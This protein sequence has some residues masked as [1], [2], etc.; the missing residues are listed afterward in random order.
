[1]RRAR[2]LVCTGW[3]AGLG[4]VLAPA[5]APAQLEGACA[6]DVE[7]LC[8]DVP[9][10]PKLRKCIKDKQPEF[11]AECKAE[12]EEREQRR[13]AFLDSCS[14]DIRTYCAN[15]ERGRGRLRRCL[16]AQENRLTP[17][18]RSALAQIPDAAESSES[19]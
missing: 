5:P 12:I 1:M 15:T 13:R 2:F 17:D 14:D 8:P 3:L 9:Q 16:Q 4:L 11:S 18:C 19:P 7:R 10:G 6:K